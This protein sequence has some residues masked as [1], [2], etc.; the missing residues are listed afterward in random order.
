MMHKTMNDLSKSTRKGAVD[1]LEARLVD[2]LDLG[3]QCKQA[4]WNVRG[5]EF[6]QLHEL[7]D[8]LYK[9]VSED[10]DDIAERATA[11]GSSVQ[12][13]AQVI[14]KRTTLKP[15]PLDAVACE[16]HVRALGAAFA[17]C[18]AGVRA[19]IEKAEKL[20]DDGTADLFTSVSRHLDKGLWLIEAHV[21]DK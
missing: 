16:D 10:V 3:L 17:A 5:R 11:L 8:M 12:A 1:L 4:H 7:F 18:V 15:Y 21:Q 9:Q 14:A 6:F 20:G 13:T 2:A 19:S